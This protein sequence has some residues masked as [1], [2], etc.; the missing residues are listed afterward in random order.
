MILKYRFAI[1]SHNPDQLAKFY[2]EVLGFTQKIKVDREEEYG[3][4]IE[5]APGYKLWIAK[6]SEISGNSK[7]PFRILLSFYVKDLKKYIKAVREFD[8]TLIVE[9]PTDYCMEI[10][11]E[12]RT[13]CA[14]HDPD[15]NTIQL[16]EQHS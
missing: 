13:V 1:N 15:G 4:G 8:S 10:K 9:E 14:F 16:M 3:Y 12:E 2:T 6:H 11:G 7:D 5:A